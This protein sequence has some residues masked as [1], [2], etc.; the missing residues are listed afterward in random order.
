MRDLTKDDYLNIA[1]DMWGPYVGFIKNIFPRSGS[2]KEEELNYLI[3][4]KDYYSEKIKEKTN[5]SLVDVDVG[6]LSD[7]ILNFTYDSV[8]NDIKK[9]DEKEISLKKKLGELE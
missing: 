1:K 5:I 8:I 9:I 4:M 7:F 6:A 3:E 2:K